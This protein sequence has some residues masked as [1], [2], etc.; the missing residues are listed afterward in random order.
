MLEF[1][2]KKFLILGVANE[3]SIAWGIAKMLHSLGAKVAFNYVNESIEKRVRPLAESLDSEIVI[4]CDVKDDA[5]ISSMFDTIKQ[6]WGNLD[7]VVH[8][9]AY[10]NRDDLQNPFYKTSREGFAEAL[11]ISAYSLI[12]I[13]NGA[14]E[15]LKNSNGSILTLTYLG[16]Q[17]V[18]KNYKVM[19]IAKAALECSVKYLAYELGEFNIRVNAISAGPLKTLAASGIPKFKELLNQFSVTA[20]LRRNVTIE[21]VSKVACF[22]LSSLSSGITG[23]I[24]YVDCGYN[25]VGIPDSE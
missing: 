4:Q 15:L 13:S 23:E 11:D 1:T 5:Q 20:P 25:T 24:T 8:S 19:G 12:A 14:S 18:I 16:S 22:Y 2:N 9:L 17:R 3:R 7:G 10:A 21:D 6:K